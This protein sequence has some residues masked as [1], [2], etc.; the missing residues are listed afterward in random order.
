[1][2]VG[3]WGIGI[4]VAAIA[5]WLVYR[6][7]ALRVMGREAEGRRM[8]PAGELHPFPGRIAAPRPRPTRREP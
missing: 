7:L 1:M 2:H 8:L 4:I 5:S 3:M 6:Y